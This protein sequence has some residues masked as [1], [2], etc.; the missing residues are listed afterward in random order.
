MNRVFLDT[1]VVVY[2]IS[3]A[4]PKR[5]IALGLMANGFIGAVQVLNEIA[6]VSRKKLGLG[7]EEVRAASDLIIESAQ[8]IA[9]TVKEDHE[10]SLRLAERYHLSI[11]DALMLAIALRA[12]CT[13]F[14]SEDMHSG[15]VIDNQL[16][17]TNPFA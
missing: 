12:G 2:A 5:P 9:P 1:N 8:H 15:L 7:W 6:N 10:L 16:T 11:Y 4:S 17:I 13:T 14:Y 3:A